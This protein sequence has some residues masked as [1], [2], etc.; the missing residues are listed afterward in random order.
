MDKELGLF[1]AILNRSH[2][3]ILLSNKKDLSGVAELAPAVKIIPT[4]VTEF[5]TNL[6]FSRNNDFNT[7]TTSS[8]LMGPQSRIVGMSR[9]HSHLW[10]V[11]PVL[12]DILLAHRFQKQLLW[13]S[14][15][16]KCWLI[17]SIFAD[18]NS[19]IESFVINRFVRFMRI[20]RIMRCRYYLWVSCNVI[21][22]HSSDS[23]PPFF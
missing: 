15:E 5:P 22:Y 9:H 21:Q 19:R 2:V 10:N 7:L 20:F 23:P 4:T 8:K 17:K 1:C 16:L 18:V 13:L 6:R 14:K 3:L 11:S 12:W